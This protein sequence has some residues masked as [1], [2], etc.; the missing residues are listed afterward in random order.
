MMGEKQGVHK[1]LLHVKD[2]LGSVKHYLVTVL[3]T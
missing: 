1:L 2:L 3:N